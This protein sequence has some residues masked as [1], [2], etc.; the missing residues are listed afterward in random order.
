MEIRDGDRISNRFIKAIKSL[1]NNP[2]KGITEIIN[3]P[4]KKP[5]LFT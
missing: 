2:G 1:R 4:P 5:L 3:N